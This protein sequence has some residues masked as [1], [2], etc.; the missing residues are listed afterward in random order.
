MIKTLLLLVSNIVLLAAGQILWKTGVNKIGVLN[1]SNICSILTSPFIW[2]GI[3]LYII[4]TVFWLV[5][6]SRASLST[7]YPVQSLAYVLGVLGGIFVFGE[8]ISLAGW[9][10]LVFIILGVSLTG[11][12]LR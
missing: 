3:L 12:G 5:V 8:S 11:I 6:L 9:L 2:A 7:V 4:A 1:W 10:G